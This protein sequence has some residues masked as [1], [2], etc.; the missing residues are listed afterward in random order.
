MTASPFH[1]FILAGC[2]LSLAACASTG[3][4]QAMQQLELQSARAKVLAIGVEKPAA[5]ASSDPLDE[6]SRR[7]LQAARRAL[8]SGRQALAVKDYR[9]AQREAERARVQLD[10]LE[11]DLRAKPNRDKQHSLKQEI[12]GLEQ[13]LAE[14]RQSVTQ[15]ESTLREL[16]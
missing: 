1:R 2:V 13:Q 11:A 8:E 16:N 5:A 10:L 3:G 15:L 14:M 6:E 7:A 4:D 12:A 9:T